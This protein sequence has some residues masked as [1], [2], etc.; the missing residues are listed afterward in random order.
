M[1]RNDG[2]VNVQNTMRGCV[3][4]GDGESLKYEGREGEIE[5]AKEGKRRERER[6]KGRNG[7]RARST[8]KEIT[9]SQAQTSALR[10]VSGRRC[11]GARVR[12]MR[13][14]SPCVQGPVC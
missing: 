2:I 9:E 3:L 12:G 4:D 1:E 6:K 14:R 7:E 8:E 11:P 5:R 13:L 10:F